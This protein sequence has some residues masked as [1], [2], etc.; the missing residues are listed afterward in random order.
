MGHQGICIGQHY[1]ALKI[2]ENKLC[3]HLQAGKLEIDACYQY[4]HTSH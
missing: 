3:P 4:I 1:L 2:S